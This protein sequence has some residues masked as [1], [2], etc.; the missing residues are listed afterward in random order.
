[1]YAARPGRVGQR[2]EAL[3]IRVARDDRVEQERDLVD[4]VGGQQGAVQR[5]AAVGADRRHAV[6]GR[7]TLESVREVDAVAT[8]LELLDATAVE[9]V[10]VGGG[11]AAR[12][13]HHHSAIP[14]LGERVDPAAH[15]AR[16]VRHDEERSRLGDERLEAGHDGQALGWWEGAQLVGEGLGR[17]EG[18]GGRA[19]HEDRIAAPAEAQAVV[20]GRIG[21]EADDPPVDAHLVVDDDAWPDHGV[22]LGPTTDRRG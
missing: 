4:E 10:A 22:T 8:G 13:E 3:T 11:G 6:G 17:P 9:V 20:A 21:L 7:E 1:V 2:D 14:G 19:A 16:A 15:G 5:A 12:D 18:E